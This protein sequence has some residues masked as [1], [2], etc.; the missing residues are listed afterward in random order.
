MER[1]EINSKLDAI[2]A[3]S[4]NHHDY[5]FTDSLKPEEVV[6]WDSLANAMII[7]AIQEQFGIKM[8][9]ADMVAWHNVGQLAEIIEKKL[10]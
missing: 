5:V 3:A 9:F 10:V 4:V 1:Q 6:G 8:K 7:T 2:I